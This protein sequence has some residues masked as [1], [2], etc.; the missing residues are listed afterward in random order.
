M[1]TFRKHATFCIQAI[2]FFYHY[3]C[4]LGIEPMTF[5]AANAMLYHWATGTPY[6]YTWHTCISEKQCYS[7]LFYFEMCVLCRNVCFWFDLCD[8]THCQFTQQ[9]FNTRVARWWKTQR[10]TAMEASKPIGSEIAVSTQPKK[11]R[12]PS[13]KLYD[14]RHIK[15]WIN[16]L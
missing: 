15:T 8:C 7:Q 1:Q 14:Q 16:Q 6:L 12:L 3:V 13:K 2:H 5:C 4:S 9:Y 11:P 10:I